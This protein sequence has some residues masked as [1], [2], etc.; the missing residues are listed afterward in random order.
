VTAN[1]NQTTAEWEQETSMM[2]IFATNHK[3]EKRLMPS[4]EVFTDTYFI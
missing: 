4:S 1:E 2:V 3:E